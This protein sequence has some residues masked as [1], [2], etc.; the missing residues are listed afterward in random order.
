MSGTQNG[1][2]RERVEVVPVRAA[3]GD[4]S[5]VTEEQES[6]GHDAEDDDGEYG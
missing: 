3:F 4:E 2:P 1:E 5:E 6:G